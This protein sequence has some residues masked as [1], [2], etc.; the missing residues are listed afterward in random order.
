MSVDSNIGMIEKLFDAF[1][2]GDIES[3]LAALTDDVDWQGPVSEHADSLPWAGRRRD[4]EQVA[5]YFREFAA[6]SQWHPM[7]DVAFTA[8]GDR[9]VVEG[10]NRNKVRA[11][12]RTY[13]HQWVM[14]FTFRNGQIARFRHYY[15]SADIAHALD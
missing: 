14:L 15:D 5:D 3:I 4:R 8:A 1:S 13:E 11:T 6:A 2:R 7:E 10:R 12:G 9:V